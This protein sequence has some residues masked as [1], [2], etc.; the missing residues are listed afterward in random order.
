MTRLKADLPIILFLL[1]E[2]AVGIM[3]LIDPESFTKILVIV[4]GAILAIIGIIYIIRYFTSVDKAG[5][6]VR[7]FMLSL[8]FL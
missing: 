3:L 1:F 4:F 2:L 6:A 7:F 8:S 5:G